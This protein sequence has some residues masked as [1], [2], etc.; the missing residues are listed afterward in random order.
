[1]LP[2]RILLVAR[3]GDLAR[4]WAI[5]FEEIE[6][7]EV[8]EGDI[9]DRDADAMVSPANS[10]GIMDGGLDAAIRD[11]LGFDVQRAVQDAILRN[12]HGELHVGQALVV[13][14]GHARWPHLVCAP[15]MRIPESVAQTTNTY[16][17]FR[18]ALLAVERANESGAAIRSM[19]CPG[20]GT[21][22][23]AMPASRCAVQMRM[24]WLQLTGP[25]RI[26]SFD[27]IHAVHKALRTS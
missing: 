5:A 25:A 20:L 22:I 10:F 2:E 12:H 27:R 14:T 4:E 17:A 23:G 8:Y 24:A 15:T 3:T 1:M 19:V 16:V 13:A 18:A 9:F 6:G 26:P 7:I 11:K 21:G